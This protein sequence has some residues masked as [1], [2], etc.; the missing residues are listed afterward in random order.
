MRVSFGDSVNKCANLR[1]YWRNGIAFKG[2]PKQLSLSS[3]NLYNYDRLSNGSYLDIHDDA[4]VPQN[5]SI[6][7]HNLS[8]LD[9][10]NSYNDQR[11]FVS[12]FKYITKFPRLDVVSENIE[13]EFVNSIKKVSRS[14]CDSKY[15]VIAA[16]Y[17]NTCSVGRRKAF[18]GSDL[19]K[20]FIILR[21]NS[22]NYGSDKSDKEI[23]NDFKSKLWAATDQRILS[24]NHDTSFPN[25][26]TLKQ[27]RNNIL[28][29][30][31][32][33]YEMHYDPRHMANNVQEEYIDLMRAA[34]FNIKIAEKLSKRRYDD[35]GE[36]INKESA[37]NFAY[38]IESV[39]D[40]KKLITS[41]EFNNLISE[42]KY[43]PFYKYS[44]VAQI[45]AIRNAIKDGFEF[46]NKILLRDKLKREFNNWTIPKQFEF[47][48]TLIRYICEDNNEYNEYFKN[49][50]DI[51]EIYEPLLG[52][53]C[54][55]DETR[56]LNPK[57]DIK[58]DR[59]NLYLTDYSPV[60][61]YQ[62]FEPNVLWIDSSKTNDIEDVLLHV[63]DL[64]KTALFKD[65]NKA[66]APCSQLEMMPNNFYPINF[67]TAKGDVIM[68]RTLK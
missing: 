33:I 15:D 17:D 10:I 51:K 53:L 6:R 32:K 46:K 25:V 49:D 44:N 58:K 14:F 9:N 37:K 35:S 38:F 45:S 20:A 18:P 68:E 36:C 1:S 21:G 5:K 67:R 65:I 4:F 41:R 30:D 40:G 42:I 47:I 29:L 7:E 59:I 3:D 12:Y 61:L 60:S 39:R 16:G 24:Y 55:G 13:K 26:M 57:F 66:Q 31:Q 19:D 48:K 8:F 64:R 23:V 2:T 27:I 34:E 63:N 28:L 22:P 54:F 43:S 50:R 56:R 62:G 52:L 11:E